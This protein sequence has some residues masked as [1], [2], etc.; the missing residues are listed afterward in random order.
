MKQHVNTF[1]FSTLYYSNTLIGILLIIVGAI[2]LLNLTNLNIKI[3]TM[4]LSIGVLMIMFYSVNETTNKTS[5]TGQ[6][7]FVIF[8]I[9]LCI[10]FLITYN[11]D[12]DIFF[13]FAILGIIT[14]REFFYGSVSS[15]LEK[16]LHVL[17]YSLIILF[18]L[19]I[20]QRI[21]LIL[22]I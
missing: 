12:A 8:T 1:S 16:R 3:G 22:H 7:I 4:L 14:L 2:F 21:M 10:S 11:I 9:W 13:I 17:F 19:I 18:I 15:R 20:T 6:K 5:F